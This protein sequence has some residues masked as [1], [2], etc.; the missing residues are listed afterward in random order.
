L[1]SVVFLRRAKKALF[2]GAIPAIAVVVF[3]ALKFQGGEP[4]VPH[5][6]DLGGAT[7]RSDATNNAFGLPAANITSEQRRLFELGDSFFTQNWVTA[8]AS[9]KARDGLGPLFNAQA[10]ASC[11][12]LDGRGAP[13]KDENDSATRGLLV[14]LSIP[15]DTPNGAPKPEPHYGDQFQDRGI[16]GVDAEGRVV[17]SYREQTGTYADGNPFS[18]RDP[19]IRF[20]DLKYGPMSPDVMTSA[21]LAP[22]IIGMGLLEAIP[23][24]DIVAAADPDDT[25]GDGVSGR[26]NY[27]ATDQAGSKAL[28]RF[29]WKAGQASV[30][31]QAAG[32]F[33]GDMGITS[34]PNPHQPCQ[35]NQTA[36]LA[37][38]T[39]G[40]PEA[41]DERMA[42]VTFYTRTLAVPVMRDHDD[43]TVAK[44]AH[45]FTEM[46][47]ALCHTPT[48]KTGEAFDVQQLSKQTFHPFTDMLLHDMGPGLADNRPEFAASGT[49]WRTPPLWGLGLANGVNGHFFLL[50][51]G[52]A[53]SFEEAILWHGGEGE[54]SKERFR[55]A[56]EKDRAALIRYLESL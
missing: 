15:G 37:A 36:C 43:K 53:R 12:V 45:Q 28:G 3:L 22:Q 49:E 41:D 56:T 16:Q 52:R 11:H 48:Q 20:E 1:S 9:T 55:N 32:A 10:C 30:Q 5:S 21:R 31:G 7:T 54:Q 46:G 33:N 47:C 14:K 17:I 24:Q 4:V 19:T 23:E 26:L 50:H 25:N 34:S 51:D 6:A 29:G 13:P 8:P 42:V 39:G 18:L 27:V 38:P 2:I 44:G 35:P 40:E